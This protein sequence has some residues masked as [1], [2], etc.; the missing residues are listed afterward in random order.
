MPT[1]SID[2]V[3]TRCGPWNHLLVD[4][5]DPEKRISELERRLS[6]S[7]G[8]EPPPM[9]QPQ[10][11]WPQAAQPQPGFSSQPQGYPGLGQGPQP[12]P[13]PPSVSPTGGQF[14][15]W[16]SSFPSPTPGYQDAPQ[17]G[18]RPW[19]RGRYLVWILVVPLLVLWPIVK[20]PVMGFVQGTVDHE[21]SA[22]QS[23]TQ[24][25]ARSALGTPAACKL[26][27]IDIAK[28]VL[29]PDTH[30]T[31]NTSGICMYKSSQ[32]F[33]SVEI[34]DWPSTKPSGPDLR[35]VQGLG[36][37]AVFSGDELYVKKGPA[38]LKI[39]L[40][41][42]PFSPGTSDDFE[43]KRDDAEKA[44]AQQMLAKL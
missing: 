15:S 22:G 30:V 32:G 20:N 33:G 11:S 8:V 31:Q 29:G 40:S 26:F 24:P 36:D 17:F 42:G 34:S 39:S 13:P 16:P 44:I 27:T 5:D 10:S 21:S 18:R 25:L 37:E 1:K 38:G 14:G 9:P 28:P 43:A 19:Q 7:Q 4:E 2:T 3:D 6:D 41:D 23:T 35:P 12:F